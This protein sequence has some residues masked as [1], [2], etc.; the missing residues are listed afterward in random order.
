M[1]LDKM[2]YTAEGLA[3]GLAVVHHVCV[4]LQVHRKYTHRRININCV[5][6]STL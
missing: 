1:P 2:R 4:C 5:H 6:V 3:K